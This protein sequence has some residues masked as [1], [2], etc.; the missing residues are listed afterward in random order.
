MGPRIGS[1]R[2]FVDVGPDWGPTR[3][4]DRDT[5]KFARQIPLH[6][7]SVQYYSL[8]DPC[9]WR[10]ITPPL[11][12]PLPQSDSIEARNAIPYVVLSSIVSYSHVRFICCN[13]FGRNM[14]F[15]RAN[16]FLSLHM[17]VHTWNHDLV[18]VRYTHVRDIISYCKHITQVYDMPNYIL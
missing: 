15:T 7:S 4:V 2:G 6:T 5:T 1:W 16:C 10:R 13:E 18:E 11:L 17:D 3:L 8:R 9:E 14:Q 12:R